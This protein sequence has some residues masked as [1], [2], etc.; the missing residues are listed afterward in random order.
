MPRHGASWC[1]QADPLFDFVF[2]NP[3]CVG[4]DNTATCTCPENYVYSETNGCE[5]CDLNLVSNDGF[6]EPDLTTGLSP[7]FTTSY[8]QDSPE[9]AD[10]S[11][12]T[13]P[14]TPIYDFPTPG[15]AGKCVVMKIGAGSVKYHTAWN[16]NHNTGVGG[17]AVGCLP[18]AGSDRALLCNGASGTSAIFRTPYVSDAPIRVLGLNDY[19]VSGFFSSV[20][21]IFAMDLRMQIC[22]VADNEDAAV[23][24]RLNATENN[25]TNW[26]DATAPLVPLQTGTGVRVCEFLESKGT[27]KTKSTTT[28]LVI[29][30]LNDSNAESG[31]DFIIDDVTLSRGCEADPATPFLPEFAPA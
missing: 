15:G 5:K 24:C 30:V 6:E 27:F 4:G 22:E 12:S 14:A 16:F 17:D 20:Y 19:T 31:N 18:R 23:V 10:L 13:Q 11:S 2:V 1:K 21:S 3:T 7:G 9:T 8:L 29:R 26:R 28:S 25:G